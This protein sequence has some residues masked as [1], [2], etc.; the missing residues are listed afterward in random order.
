MFKNSKTYAIHKIL[1]TLGNFI[2]HYDKL[3]ISSNLEFN[4][5]FINT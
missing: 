3:F 1:K 4:N 5:N 2:C